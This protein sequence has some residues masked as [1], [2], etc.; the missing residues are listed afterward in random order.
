MARQEAIPDDGLDRSEIWVI[1]GAQLYRE[2]L[3]EANKAYVTL[4]DAT[5]DA[6]AYAPDMQ[7]LVDSGEWKVADRSPWMSAA[8]ADSGVAGYRFV[9]YVR[10]R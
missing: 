10:E 3:P 1:G 8:S 7:A 5:V 2:M 6:D 9:T 4:V